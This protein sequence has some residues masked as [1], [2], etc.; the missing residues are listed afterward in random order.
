M[1][2][3]L[4]AIGSATVPILGM[5]DHPAP[6]APIRSRLFSVSGWAWG[7]H[8]PVS[9]VEISIGRVLVGRAGLAR[10]RPDVAAHLG[11][12]GAV[13]AGFDCV[14]DL[15]LL[16]REA[17][18]YGAGR[19][20]IVAVGVRVTLVDGT[21][22][23]LAPVEVRL[24]PDID[25]VGEDRSGRGGRSF[26]I[27]GPR[28]HVAP[29][30]RILWL[31]RSLDRGGSQLRML[32]LVQHLQAAGSWS[33]TVVAPCEG[34]LRAVLE[35]AGAVVQ[36]GEPI[37]LHDPAAYQRR[38]SELA[39]W[40]DERFDLVLGSTMT[41][42]PAADLAGRLGL[43]SV[44]RVGEA[45]PLRTV[46]G[47]LGGQLHP[48]V[49]RHAMDC[50]AAAS[51][52]LF[53]SMAA[54]RA[55]QAAGGRGRCTLLR[56][57]IDLPVKA[58]TEEERA[59]CR[60]RLGVASDRRLVVNASTLWPIKGQGVLAAALDFVRAD[61]PEL[62]CVLVGTA[63]GPYAD[64][65]GRFS[66]RNSL[67]SVLRV[68]PFCD[69]LRPWWGAADAVI[70]SSETESLPASLLEAMAFGVPV[71]STRVGDLIDLVRPGVNGWLCDPCDV[72]SMSVGLRAVASCTP[73]ELRSL[74]AAAFATASFHDAARVL[75]RTVELLEY[76]A[77]GHY[78]QWMELASPLRPATRLHRSLTVT[79]PIV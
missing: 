64:A 66:A 3:D 33:N 6:L 78:P 62:E 63:E 41:S 68:V 70:C 30:V 27:T 73:G 61:C 57:G 26:R 45:E 58:S 42:F 79:L 35:A 7:L 34:P 65:I 23:S 31:A 11:D 4:T 2:P 39:E 44:I 1:T 15:R 51:A 77:G 54:L 38:V 67:G 76:L 5:I 29:P 14:V 9:Q 59:L 13:L 74:G 56:T 75:P 36:V 43:P 12:D 32:E 52:V 49:E 21:Q 55:F 40:A 53:T 48:T 71:L 17:V 16:D 50:F 25:E 18:G 37:P 10:P 22:G 28:R 69:D 20:G 19:A 60:Q 46:V 72:A 24:E 8:S 47:W